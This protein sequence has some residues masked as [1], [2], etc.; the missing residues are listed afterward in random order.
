MVFRLFAGG[1][2][3]LGVPG[4]EATVGITTPESSLSGGGTGGGAGFSIIL[5]PLKTGGTTFVGL[6]DLATAS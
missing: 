2:T 5:L 6:S 4:G 1:A 3:G